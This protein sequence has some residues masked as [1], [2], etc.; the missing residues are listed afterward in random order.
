MEALDGIAERIDKD[1]G[2]WEI[3][4]AEAV[5]DLAADHVKMAEIKASF[6]ERV[7]ALKAEA[8]A[9]MSAIIEA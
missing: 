9:Q 6:K 7:D 5:K 8:D 1:Q 4:T 3:H 2:E